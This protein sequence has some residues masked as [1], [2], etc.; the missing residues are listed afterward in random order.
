MISH[1]VIASDDSVWIATQGEG[2]IRHRFDDQGTIVEEN[3]FLTSE[4]ATHILEDDGGRIWVA[5]SLGLVAIEDGQ[6]E[7]YGQR[8]GL[9]PGP[10]Y[11]VLIDAQGRLLAG[12]DSGVFERR[13]KHFHPL[14]STLEGLSVTALLIDDHQALWAGTV[15]R[16]LARINDE[17]VAWLGTEQGL[18]NNRIL[19]LYKDL[20]GS[21]WVGTGGGLARLRAAPFVTFTREHGLAGN[22]V[23]AV[24][25]HSDGSLWIGTSEGASR[26][27]NKKLEPVRVDGEPFSLSVLSLAETAGGDV[28]IGT[29]ANGVKH[30][31]D[32][33]IVARYRREEGLPSNDIRILTEDGQGRIWIGTASGL[34]RIE[35][36][37]MRIF[38]PEDGLPG[39]FV[40]ALHE[41]ERGNIWVGTGFG[42]ARIAGEQI[43]PFSLHHLDDALYVYGIHDDEDDHAL[44]LTTDRGLARFDLDTRQSAIIGRSAGMPIDKYFHMVE[45]H[46]GGFWLTS[47]RGILRIEKSDAH[48][49]LQGEIDSIPFELYTEGDGMKSAQANGGSGPPAAF[50]DERVW[51]ATAAGLASVDPLHLTRYEE[52]TL[53]VNIEQFEVDGEAMGLGDVFRLPANSE[54]IA[55]QYA[56]LGFIMPERIV[57]RTRLE[58]F[59][60]D[61][62]ERGHQDVA[63]YTNLGPGTYTFHVSAAYPYGSWS[64]TAASLE[65]SVAPEI[66]QRSS[67]WILAATASFALLLLL[68][69]LRIRHLELRA[70]QLHA[71]VDEKTRELKRQSDY[72]QRQARIDQLTGLANR[73]AFDEW[74][75]REFRDSRR[76]DRPL[77]L[78]ILDLDHFK[79]INDDYTH[80]IGD[81]IMQVVA[82]VLR[83]HIR[84][85]DQAARWGGEEFTLTFPDRRARDAAGICERIRQAM[86]QT[87]FSDIAP[88]LTITASFGISDNENAD[89]Y[90]T[91]LRQADQAL[92]HAKSEGR[93]R[94]VIYNNG[95]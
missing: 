51:I 62:V 54:R 87:D 69:R 74:L 65:F 66:W 72:F 35:N 59:Q 4:S 67:F 83:R 53:P 75:A 14:A 43:E 49:V 16:G 28:L 41:D 17:G 93:N 5:S 48:A 91:L 82:R 38:Q 6:L 31:R 90:E 9:P 25:P 89:S 60:S 46:R 36:G 55:I 71:Q 37:A 39:D 32:G 56:G 22:Y 84:E 42:L 18:P 29:H 19:S 44:W 58:G 15:N 12:T 80:L 70:R 11:T 57:Y 76:R 26:L 85:K 40:I 3:R 45:D 21:L 7:A 27:H 61:W 94:V 79:R 30:W 88:G 50:H 68:I 73:R 33:R 77:S 23:R 63:E 2:I 24:L 8:H 34:V 81:R 1:A 64:G 10:V 86:E 52:I 47:N 20:E 13:D 95:R 92:Y 78:A